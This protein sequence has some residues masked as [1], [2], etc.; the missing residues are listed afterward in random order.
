MSEETPQ[1]EVAA[2]GSSEPEISALEKEM[3][4]LLSTTQGVLGG[5]LSA[6]VTAGKIRRKSKDLEASLD[7]M[8][9][10][11]AWNALGGGGRR[12]RRNSRDYTDEQLMEAFK[13][14]DTDQSGHIDHAELSAAIREMDPNVSAVTIAE[15]MSFADADGN[16]EVDFDEFKKIMLYKASAE[17]NSA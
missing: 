1:P 16:G 15:M 3:N 4:A 12:S 10:S 14:I 7:M 17:T 5:A 11:D 13:K 2:E 9:A 8:A 6:K